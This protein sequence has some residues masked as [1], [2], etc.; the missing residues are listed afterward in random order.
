ML[1]K[2]F[3]YAPKH[4]FIIYDDN[5]VIIEINVGDKSF[6]ISY[7]T[8]IHTKNNTKFRTLPKNDADTAE[9][10]VALPEMDKDKIMHLVDNIDKLLGLIEVYQ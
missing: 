1:N 4:D 9:V 7:I 5:E 6:Y 8:I 3:H 2:K 10:E